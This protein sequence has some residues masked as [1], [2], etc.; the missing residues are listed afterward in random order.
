MFPNNIRSGTGGFFDNEQQEEYFN[1]EDCNCPQCIELDRVEW[2]WEH[3]NPQD[4]FIQLLKVSI[5]RIDIEE[6]MRELSF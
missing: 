4:P 6:I 1:P 2:A 3:W 5:E